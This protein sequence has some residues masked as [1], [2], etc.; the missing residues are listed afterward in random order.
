MAEPSTDARAVTERYCAAW[1]G[2]D[3]ESLLDS[4]ADDIVLHYFGANQLSGD[5]VGKDAAVAALVAGATI[6]TR[7]LLSVDDIMVG[8]DTSTVV[9]TERFTRDDESH[10]LTRVLRYRIEG[11]RF[12]E[13]WLYDEDQ[14]LVDH[15]WR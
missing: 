15:L 13:C 11:E 4:Y 2:G 1:V 3:F 6:T 7:E 14:P 12:A 10:V 5:H 8:D 9:V